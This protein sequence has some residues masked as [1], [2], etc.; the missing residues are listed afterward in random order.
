MN[1]QHSKVH[2]EEVCEDHTP[3]LCL[4]RHNVFAVAVLEEIRIGLRT[5]NGVLGNVTN[6][7]AGERSGEDVR[8]AHEPVAEVV[9]VSCSTP[10]ARHKKTRTSSG[11]D[12][13]EVL[14]AR[15]LRVGAETILLVV[16]GTEDVVANALNGKNGDNTLEAEVDRVN[17][18]VASLQTVC[19]RNPNKVTE[20][21]HHTEAVSDQI[22]GGKDRG[23]HVQGIEGVDGLRNSDKNDRVSDAAVVA[24]LLHDEGKIH[25]D[26]AEHTWAQL[27]PGLDIDLSED[28]ED[29][30]GVELAA[31]EPVVQ[32]VARVATG[33]K[34]THFRVLGVL[35][36]E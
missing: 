9:D 26:P 35:D 25:D 36:T 2:H 33:C 10:P 6:N 32:D 16:D 11:L 21:Q 30:T 31:N 5:L 22:N 18:K 15:I 14:D 20:R 23:L 4:T 34:L 12:V 8:P 29:D 24:V 7:I 1:E 13:L 17:G 27:A 3:A 19:K 28:G